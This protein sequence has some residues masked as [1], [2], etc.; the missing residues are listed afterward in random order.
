MHRTDCTLPLTWIFPATR[1][2]SVVGQWFGSLFQW[3]WCSASWNEKTNRTW[4]AVGQYSNIG[5]TS[6]NLWILS[7][8]TNPRNGDRVSIRSEMSVRPGEIQDR[9]NV[10]YS[11]HCYTSIWASVILPTYR[12]PISMTIAN[13][14]IRLLIFAN[15][16]FRS[17]ILFRKCTKFNANRFEI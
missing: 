4:F 16:V 1:S 7:T 10:L 17:I 9:N 13:C 15:C 6:G 12:A 5:N 3:R 11:L 8:I 2:N 14:L